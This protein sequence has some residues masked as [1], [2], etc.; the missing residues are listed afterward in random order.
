MMDG[1]FQASRLCFVASQI[2]IMPVE[3]F[4]REYPDIRES[5]QDAIAEEKELSRQI[6]TLKPRSGG[7]MKVRER[8][9]LHGQ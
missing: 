5:M 9:T 1:N 6:R 2:D 4:M 8:K 7:K 3:E